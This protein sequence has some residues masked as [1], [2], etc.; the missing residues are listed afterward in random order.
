M[1]G[2]TV[3]ALGMRAWIL[4]GVGDIRYEETPL[5]LPKPEEVLLRVHGA[6]ICGSDIPRIYE[7][8]AHRMPLVSKH[9]NPPEQQS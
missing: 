4:H 2:K 3:R 8:G 1:K 9:T 6:G 5:P 7:T